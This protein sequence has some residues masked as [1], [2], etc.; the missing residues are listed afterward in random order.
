[1]LSVRGPD[2]E[3]TMSLAWLAP[4]EWRALL[5]AAGFAIEA[6]YGWFDRSRWRGGED[7]IWIA[8][9]PA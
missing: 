8:Q 4:E 9:R 1:V 2:A 7:S 5:L 3:A 6:H